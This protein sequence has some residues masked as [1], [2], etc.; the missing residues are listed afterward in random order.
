MWFLLF[1]KFFPS[2]AIAEVKEALPPPR[3]QGAAR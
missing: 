2:V 3:A 1:I